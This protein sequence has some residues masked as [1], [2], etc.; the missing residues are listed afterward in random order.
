LDAGGDDVATTVA[1]ASEAQFE[2]ENA[3]LTALTT[4][5]TINYRTG[6]LTTGI[7]QFVT[8]T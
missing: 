4:D 3:S 6:A 1:G 5:M 8:G 2:T 7:S